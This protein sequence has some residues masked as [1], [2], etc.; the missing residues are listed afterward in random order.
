VCLPIELLMCVRSGVFATTVNRDM[1]TSYTC[2]NCRTQLH[3]PLEWQPVET[4]NESDV[5]MGMSWSLR[6]D[7]ISLQQEIEFESEPSTLRRWTTDLMD[8][9]ACSR[10]ISLWQRG[11]V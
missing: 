4:S 5:A 3:E 1:P 11:H 7:A 6:S 2:P 8:W 9:L 10:R